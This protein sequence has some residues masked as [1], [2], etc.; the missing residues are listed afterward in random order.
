MLLAFHQTFVHYIYLFHVFTFLYF[1]DEAPALIWLSC[2]KASW[3]P[4]CCTLL[5]NLLSTIII[6]VTA[7]YVTV[8]YN[9]PIWTASFDYENGTGDVQT[10]AAL[11]L[12]CVNQIGS[13]LTW[14]LIVVV[15]GT[16]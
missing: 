8:F 3:Q 1:H 13:T 6:I 5:D 10:K 12:F 2:G 14:L 9:D 16:W 7:N 11:N 15:S 4:F